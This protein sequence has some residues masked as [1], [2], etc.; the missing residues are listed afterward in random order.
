LGQEPG[1]VDHRR[2]V[3][4]KHERAHVEEEQQPADREEDRDEQ[5][6]H[7]ADEDVGENELPAHPPEQAVAG[8]DVNAVADDQCG[9]EN[10]EAAECVQGVEHGSTPS[11]RGP[12]PRDELERDAGTQQAAGESPHQPDACSLET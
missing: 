1:A 9:D 6:R 3:I 5:H 11:D 2:H 7:D 8:E 4:A 12:Q 10:G